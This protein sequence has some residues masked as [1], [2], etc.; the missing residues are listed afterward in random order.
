MG[1]FTGSDLNT[2]SGKVSLKIVT[3][4]IGGKRFSNLLTFTSEI[5][6]N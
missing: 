1:V 3:L 6:L 5:A 4:C 2:P